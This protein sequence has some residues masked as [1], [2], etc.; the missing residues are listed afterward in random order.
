MFVCLVCW[1]VCLYLALVAGLFEAAA[2]KVSAT[3]PLHSVHFSR[4][5]GGILLVRSRV[6]SEAQTLQCLY[7]NPSLVCLS[8]YLL[9]CLFLASTPACWRHPGRR[10][11]CR[12]LGQNLPSHHSVGAPLSSLRDL[13]S[14]DEQPST[15]MRTH[16]LIQFT[17]PS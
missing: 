11:P 1:A 9:V 3:D 8:S 2:C 6:R 16:I 4:G 15:S 14:D 5:G 13:Q 17:R 12:V 10:I 7:A